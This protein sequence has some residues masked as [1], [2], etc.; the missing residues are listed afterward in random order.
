MLS[1]RVARAVSAA[2]HPF[3]LIPVSIAIATRA[4]FWAAV[5]AATTI[6]PL[7]AFIAIQVRRGAWSDFDVSRHEQRHGLYWALVPLL[8]ACAIVLRMNHAAPQM[9]RGLLASAVMLAAGLFAN[10]FLKVSLHSMFA[11]FSAAIVIRGLPIAA[12]FAILVVIAV[13]WSRHRLERHTL[14]EIATGLVFGIA[15]GIFAVM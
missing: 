15:G 12:P 14:M 2:G 10:R 5:I 3:V 4:W 8:A 9:M 6:L 7:L 1:L 13:A 11:A